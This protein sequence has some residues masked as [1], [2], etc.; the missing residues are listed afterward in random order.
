MKKISIILLSF[1]TFISPAIAANE[2]TIELKATKNSINIWQGLEIQAE[3]KINSE[4]QDMQNPEIEIPWL[5]E[6]FI[7]EWNTSMVNMEINSWKRNIKIDKW[8]IIRAK[9][10]WTFKIWPAIVKYSWKEYRSNMI[11]ISVLEVNSTN[12]KDINKRSEVTPQVIDIP[13][14]LN[15]NTQNYDIANT[16]SGDKI[17][18]II[19]ISIIVLSIIIISAGILVYIKLTP[20]NEENIQ[21]KEISDKIVEKDLEVLV[22]EKLNITSNNLSLEEGL[23]EFEKI[24]WKNDILEAAI[25]YLVKKKYWKKTDSQK[26]S[27]LIKLLDEI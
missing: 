17:P 7:I 15:W 2:V 5:Q 25:A 12:T 16:N 8:Y 22:K 23:K 10:T 1:I 20:R 18:S 19:N 13:D 27:E 3:M 26:E 14:S 24:N 6:W 21:I 4:N 9:K 11:E